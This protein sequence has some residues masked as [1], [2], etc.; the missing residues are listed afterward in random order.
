MSLGQRIRQA[1]RA[2]GLSLRDL[3]SKIGVSPTAISNYERGQDTPRPSVLVRLARALE[4]ES[5]FFFREVNVVLRAPAYRKH[6]GLSARSRLSFESSVLKILEKYLMI[7]NL[8][9][10]RRRVEFNTRLEP[11]R[12]IEDAETAAESLRDCWGLGFGPIYDLMAVLEDHG[13]K[14]IALSPRHGFDGFS[15]WANDTIPVVVCSSDAPGDR[16]RF[17]LAHELGHLMLGFSDAVDV[18]SAAHRFAAALLVPRKAVF[19]ELG[20]KRSRLTM[21]ELHIL[22]HKYGLSMQAWARRAFDLGIIACSVYT[23]VCKQFSKLGWRKEEPGDQVPGE[24]PRRCSMLVYQAIAEDLVSP[25]TAE[26]LLNYSYDGKKP[27]L[28]VASTQID[29]GIVNEYAS[30]I[31]LTAFT[32][33]NAED[34][35]AYDE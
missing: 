35:Y 6:S 28:K 21:E 1:R 16:Q 25:S 8:F 26:S 34:I 7:E 32:K 9:P 29:E 14:V 30:N 12:S 15:C 27:V 5:E 23:G 33:A 13:V 17:T 10:K 3:A 4:V 11:V 19:H 31:D 2:S 22:K 24:T 20:E 18:E